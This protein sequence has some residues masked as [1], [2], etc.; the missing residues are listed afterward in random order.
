MNIAGCTK[1]RKRAFSVDSGRLLRWKKNTSDKEY[2]EH[3]R[4]DREVIPVERQDAVAIASNNRHF[5]LRETFNKVLEIKR[6]AMTYQKR[7]GV[8]NKEG[9][10]V[11]TSNGPVHNQTHRYDN[12]DKYRVIGQILNRSTFWFQ[13]LSERGEI[14]NLWFENKAH[15]C[16]AMTEM[17]TQAYHHG[18][19]Q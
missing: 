5:N 10:S 2:H 4:A 1:I 12:G 14:Y 7:H 17:R 3:W 19:I 16:K 15:V 13:C 9:D 11:R 18:S 6:C 8:G